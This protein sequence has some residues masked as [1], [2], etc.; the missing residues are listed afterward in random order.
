LERKSKAE[1]RGSEQRGMT[2]IVY[3]MTKRDNLRITNTAKG[4]SFFTNQSQ[5]FKFNISDKLTFMKLL[6]GRGTDKEDK[7]FLLGLYDSGG[8]CT[9]GWLEY[10]KAIY[11]KHPQY[12]CK[13]ICLEESKFK[14]IGIEGIKDSVAITHMVVQLAVFHDTF[15]I[16]MK[17]PERVPIESLEYKHQT[18]QVMLVES[19]PT[20][21]KE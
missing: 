20:F 10:H 16:D 5:Q 7:S 4:V 13:F 12:V 8:R 1:K 3:R 11:T 15:T 17:T 21:Q 19:N 2:F 14:N 18:P 6:I 9:M